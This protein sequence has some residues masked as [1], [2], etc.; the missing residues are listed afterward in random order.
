MS[1]EQAELLAKDVNAAVVRVPGRR[2]PG[3]VV[4]AD[5]L[6]IIID[7]AESV[8]DCLQHSSESERLDE[9][10]EELNSML[11]TLRGYRAVFERVMK[12]RG[13]SLPY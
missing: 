9:A 4:Q 2:Y 7:A 8:L 11:S 6:K 5:S 3:V 12:E 13:E 1:G 10:R